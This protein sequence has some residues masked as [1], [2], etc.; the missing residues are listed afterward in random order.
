MYKILDSIPVQ[1]VPFIMIIEHGV[2]SARF[3]GENILDEFS[4]YINTHKVITP[5]SNGGNNFS[6]A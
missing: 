6:K 4:E 1:G 3:T 5:I 2:I